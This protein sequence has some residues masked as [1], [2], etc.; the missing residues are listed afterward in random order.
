MYPGFLGYML[1]GYMCR[2]Y[3]VHVPGRRMSPTIVG[4]DD[5]TPTDAAAVRLRA[6]ALA[7][8]AH[9]RHALGVRRVGFAGKALRR[10]SA[11]SHVP[12]RDDTLH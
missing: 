8:D 7:A 5:L 11:V 6:L 9:I 4:L 10:G 12:P 2:G 1:W 3:I